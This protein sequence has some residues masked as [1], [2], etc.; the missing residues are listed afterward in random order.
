MEFP[1]QLTLAPNTD[2][3]LCHSPRTSDGSC[4][5][6]GGQTDPVPGTGFRPGDDLSDYLADRSMP[7]CSLATANVTWNLCTARA[8]FISTMPLAPFLYV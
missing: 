5:C 4:T 3:V 7:Y 1:T 8:P 6:G 2:I